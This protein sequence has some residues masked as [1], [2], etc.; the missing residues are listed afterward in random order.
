[1]PSVVIQEGFQALASFHCPGDSANVV[2]RRR[3]L[4][5]NDGEMAAPGQVVHL[6]QTPPLQR[7]RDRPDRAITATGRGR[8]GIRL[9]QSSLRPVATPG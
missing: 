4:Q 8:T 6:H 5:F 3:F 7:P 1:M 9:W 2:L